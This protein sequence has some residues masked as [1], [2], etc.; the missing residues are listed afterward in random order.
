MG[1]AR[2]RNSTEKALRKAVVW[3]VGQIRFQLEMGQEWPNFQSVGVAASHPILR[4]LFMI[5]CRHEGL[6]AILGYLPG[7][8]RRRII[9][10]KR[11]KCQSS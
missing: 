2:R 4:K 1:L 8:E 9:P 6:L 3:E 11:S 5:S 10:L 7:A